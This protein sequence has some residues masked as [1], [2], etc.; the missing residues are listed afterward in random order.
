MNSQIWDDSG[1]LKSAAPCFKYKEETITGEHNVELC[2]LVLNGNRMGTWF[3][4]NQTEEEILRPGTAP[5]ISN[6]GDTI[7]LVL[8]WSKG[9]EFEDERVKHGPSL[10]IDS[11]TNTLA[12]F[13]YQ[14]NKR[15]NRFWSVRVEDDMI[16]TEEGFYQDDVKNGPF[17]QG[18]SH[19]ISPEDI[20]W[21]YGNYEGGERR[22]EEDRI[23]AIKEEL[24]E[25]KEIDRTD[26]MLDKYEI[27]IDTYDLS[28]WLN[29]AWEIEIANTGVASFFIDTIPNHHWIWKPIQVV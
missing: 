17:R 5:F 1:Q 27:E 26:I 2:G 3:Y 8:T 29:T 11:G 18:L 24:E 19:I 21:L 10:L 25:T 15:Q 9:R 12:Q 16:I 7:G 20:V 14:N 22:Y 23:E 4:L 13:T 6:K 28:N